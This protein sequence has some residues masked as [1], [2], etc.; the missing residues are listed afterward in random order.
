MKCCADILALLPTEPRQSPREK[1]SVKEGEIFH[2]T[3]AQQMIYLELFRQP[4]TTAYNIPLIAVIPQAIAPQRFQQALQQAAERFPA[5]FCRFY[6]ENGQL[7]FRYTGTQ[8]VP[9]QRYDNLQQGSAIF[10]QP[11]QLNKDLL[12]RAAIVP[13]DGQQTLLMLDFCHI[14]ADGLSVGFFLRQLRAALLSIPQT[15]ETPSLF[16]W[17]CWMQQAEYRIERAE[18]EHFWHKRLSPAPKK[19]RWPLQ[20]IPKSNG[21]GYAVQQVHLDSKLCSTIRSRARVEEVTPFTLF[22]LAWAL[23][24]SDVTECWQGRVGLVVSGRHAPAWQETF[25]MFVNTLLLPVDLEPQQSI[26]DTLAALS[27]Q[28]QQALAN[29]HYPFIAQRELLQDDETESPLDAL[30][31]FQNIDYQNI[32]FLGGQFRTFYEAKRMAQFGMVI[33]VFDRQQQGY[34]IQWEHA[35]ECFSSSLVTSLLRRYQAILQALVT[36]PTHLP[37]IQCIND[38]DTTTSALSNVTT[39]DFNFF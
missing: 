36:H 28:T 10:V 34:E 2:Q 4:D 25:G 12:L 24:Q 8:T 20:Q 27:Q 32:D 22:L 11:Y 3:D 13:W 26:A 15:E 29:Q 21:F 39:V 1:E 38:E 9:L 30:F 33:H 5:L 37:I 14:A 6:D 7:L 31:A 18:A 35:P 19:P 16:A 17:S 23:L